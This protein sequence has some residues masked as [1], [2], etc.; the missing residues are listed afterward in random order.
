MKRILFAALFIMMSVVA[1]GQNGIQ[2]IELETYYVTNAADQTALGVPAGS[3]TYRIW[4]ELTPGWRLNSIFAAPDGIG[5][6]LHNLKVETTTSFFNANGLFGPAF[7]PTYVSGA[8]TIDKAYMIDS[9]FSVGRGAADKAAV[10]KALDGDGSLAGAGPALQNND[11]LAGTP[12]TTADGLVALGAF[13]PPAAD[14]LG[15]ESQVAFT[16]GGS[17]INWEDGA[18]YN[19]A[20]ILP[21]S[22]NRICIDQ[23]TTDGTLTYE[24]NLQVQNTTSGVAQN[25]VAAN[26]QVGEFTAPFMSYYPNIAPV[27]NITS[28]ASGTSYLSG[29]S[30]TLEA[31]ATDPD[32]TIDSVRFYRDGIYIG[33]DLT[34]V[35][36]VFSYTFNI[37]AG[38]NYTAR[39]YDND[40]DFT[41]STAVSLIVGANAAPVVTFTAPNAGAQVKIGNPV[42]ITVDAVDATGNVASVEF[43]VDGASIGLGTQGVGN[44]WSITWANATPL[45]FRTLSAVATDDQAPALSNTPVTR[46]IQVVSNVPPAVFINSPVN[47]A[48]FVMPATITI[49]AS[50]S[51]VDGTI[52]DVEFY[53]DGVLVGNDNS[54]PS[55][56]FDW[57]ATA[58]TKVL[59]AKA[60]D[61]D[62][63]ITTS[64]AVTIDVADPNSL[65]YTFG[66]LSEECTAGDFCLPVIK[67]AFPTSLSNCIGFDMVLNYDKTKVNPT[68]IIIIDNDLIT[69]PA[70]ASYTTNII[71]STAQAHIL[72]SVYL[73]QTAPLGTTWHGTGNAFCVQ[74]T[75]TNG[76]DPV[77]TAMFTAASFRESYNTGVLAKLVD[78]GYYI[79]Y[80]DTTFE[81]QLRFW[82]GYQP[83]AYNPALPGQYLI[84][85]I[86]GS[87]DSS[88]VY[89]P[90]T[91]GNFT[92]V[93]T[94]G[95]AI[96][97]NRDIDAGTDVMPVINGADHLL[98]KM[99]L[100]DNINFVPN[101]FQIIAMDVNTD[102]VVSAGDL[103]QMMQRT[104]L[105]IP[106]FRQDWNYNNAGISDGRASK[107]WLFFDNKYLDTA[108]YIIS[109][110]YPFN[111][112]L[113]YSKYN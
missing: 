84:T 19:L 102:G 106:E 33:K 12:L 66:T 80:I 72:I 9:W 2:N 105:E 10:K 63:G 71:D 104:V 57:T 101:V 103:S 74:F 88:T 91:S 83:I 60:F 99:V 86:F 109:S 35:G 62:G 11:P 56:T 76:F 79:S 47:G 3:K 8:F 100:V 111:D 37:L 89:V 52:S 97:I 45:G 49:D 61:N 44:S 40:G 59:T 32:G 55:Y 67:N 85:E 110:T 42:N 95:P 87:T 64:N 92:Y 73:N 43:F 82:N 22:D 75:K 54:G 69:N 94:H 25:W 7:T 90:N 24:F 34:P 14:I 68:G 26:Q 51:D 31:T 18:I 112:G 21:N 20:G 77:D 48:G 4:V 113:G 46:Q 50:A 96:N 81:G 15:T 1:F 5:D 28:P 98:T 41:T 93:V 36:N 23:V 27:V 38:G 6:P 107:D 58:G 17:S 30:V 13:A 108:D 65:P 16:T 78:T 39:A 70:Y 53:V 29:A